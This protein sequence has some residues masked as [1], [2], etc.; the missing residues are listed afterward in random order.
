MSDL[1]DENCMRNLFQKEKIKKILNS[2]KPLDTGKEDY[3][4]VLN[5]MKIILNKE[6][7]KQ[8]KIFN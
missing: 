3:K 7:N 8:S 4:R 6:L 2:T 5:K 1:E